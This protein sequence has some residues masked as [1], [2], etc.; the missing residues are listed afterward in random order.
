MESSG[1]SNPKG[2]Y[3]NR[4]NDTKLP[5]HLNLVPLLT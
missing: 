2:A 3:L 4:T 5:Y 1:E